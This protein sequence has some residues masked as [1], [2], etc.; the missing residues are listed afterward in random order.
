M[1]KKKETATIAWRAI[2]E[3]T[4]GQQQTT[5]C[6]HGSSN[7]VLAFGKLTKSLSNESISRATSWVPGQPGLM[8][9]H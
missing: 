3:D 1:E 8:T 5:I 6:T 2:K 4:Q 7:L 9:S